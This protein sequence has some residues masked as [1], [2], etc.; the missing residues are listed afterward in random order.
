[1]VNTYLDFRISERNGSPYISEFYYCSNDGLF[2]SSSHLVY[3]YL[4][5]VYSSKVPFT[6]NNLCYNYPN[7]ILISAEQYPAQ[8]EREWYNRANFSLMSAYQRLYTIHKSMGG[9]HIEDKIDYENPVYPRFIYKLELDN[10]LQL[11]YFNIDQIYSTPFFTESSTKIDPT[12]P[13][14]ALLLYPLLFKYDART[15][16]YYAYNP[17][18]GFSDR[19]IPF[20]ET[21]DTLFYFYRMTT[22]YTYESP[23]VLVGSSGRELNFSMFPV[24]RGDQLWN[25]DLDKLNIGKGLAYV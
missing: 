1:M 24:K 8:C 5:G 9:N 13:P 16:N 20:N 17:T 19:D 10:G 3:D 18:L 12:N 4:R 23:S 22:R 15:Q 6:F 11:L 7:R 14:Y 21:P 25:I 2:V